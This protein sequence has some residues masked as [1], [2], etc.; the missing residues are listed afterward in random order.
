VG[1]FGLRGQLV[2]GG[3]GVLLEP[4]P[5]G[6]GDVD[7]VQVGAEVAAR[8][9]QLVQIDQGHHARMLGRPGVQQRVVAHHPGRRVLLS[10]APLGRS[11]L[12][13]TYGVVKTITLARRLERMPT[14]PLRSS[15]RV[16]P[17]LL[18]PVGQLGV[19]VVVGHLEAPDQRTGHL[20]PGVAD[21]LA[22]GAAPGWA[23]GDRRADGSAHEDAPVE[24]E[25]VVIATGCS[26]D[27]AR[28]S[29][30]VRPTAVPLPI[31]R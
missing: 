14:A 16:A 27:R 29:A 21:L 23:A 4:L 6:P 8:V 12:G 24:V 2:D 30:H 28:R 7:A 17:Q 11:L 26:P 18:A 22:P 25:V 10:G 19:V 15:S 1:R 5:A 31:R 9:D 13:S 3:Q 20:G